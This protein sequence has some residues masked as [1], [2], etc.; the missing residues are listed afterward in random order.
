MNFYVNF[1]ADF[2]LN[3]SYKD[4]R[5]DATIMICVARKLPV[6]PHDLENAIRKAIEFW[7]YIKRFYGEEA[8]SLQDCPKQIVNYAET[9]DDVVLRAV[10]EQRPDVGEVDLIT[11]STVREVRPDNVNRYLA[12]LTKWFQTIH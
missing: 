12:I 8:R 3:K 11:N 7:L 2:E 9:R 4:H 6:T 5:K 10:S 1:Y